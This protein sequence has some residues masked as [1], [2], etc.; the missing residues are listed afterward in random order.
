MCKLLKRLHRKV[1][2]NQM[3]T[4]QY[5]ALK[6]E[7]EA[8]AVSVASK[9]RNSQFLTEKANNTRDAM[10]EQQNKS[11]TTALPPPSPFL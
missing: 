8:A 1:E 9:P 2:E 11:P 3:V 10:T 4:I 6:Y 7:I 5:G